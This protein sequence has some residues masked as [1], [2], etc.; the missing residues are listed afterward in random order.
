[1]SAT[2]RRSGVLTPEREV[3]AVEAPARLG[4]NA[5]ARRRGE[6]FLER[7]PMS[8]HRSRVERWMNP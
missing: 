3:I 7:W 4:R 1:M 8:V 2:P 6:R 5:E